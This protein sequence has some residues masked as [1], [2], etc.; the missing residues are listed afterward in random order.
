[1]TADCADDGRGTLAPTSLAML[2]EFMSTATN[3]WDLAK[4][5]V[6]DLDGGSGPARGRGRR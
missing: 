4:T 3:G 6:R 5:S 1:M 2:Q